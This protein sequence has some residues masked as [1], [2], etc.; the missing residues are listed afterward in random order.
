MKGTKVKAPKLIPFEDKYNLPRR[1]H[2]VLGIINPIHDL[3]EKPKS[4]ERF[5]SKLEPKAIQIMFSY[6]YSARS[7]LIKGILLIILLTLLST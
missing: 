6:F 7:Q 1:E 2:R 5:S 4:Q 3:P